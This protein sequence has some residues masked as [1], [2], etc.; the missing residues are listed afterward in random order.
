MGV[1]F[2]I[3][4]SLGKIFQS[5][6]QLLWIAIYIQIVLD[7]VFLFRRKFVDHSQVLVGHH[8]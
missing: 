3:L 8:L 2:Q 6:P 1:D 5:Q 4:P 7:A